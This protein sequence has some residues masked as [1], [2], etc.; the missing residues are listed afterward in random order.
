M[1]WESKLQI[2]EEKDFKFSVEPILKMVAPKENIRRAYWGIDAKCG[3]EGYEEVD[4][5]SSRWPVESNS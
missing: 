1:D 5:Y 2:A 3:A 4:A